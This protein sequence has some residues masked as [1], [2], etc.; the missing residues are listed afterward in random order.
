MIK[1]MRHGYFEL[2]ILASTLAVLLLASVFLDLVTI[3]FQHL[4]L[5]REAAVLLLLACLGGSVVNIPLYRRRMVVSEEPLIGF[6]WIFYRPPMFT[7]Q[8][9]A[10]N[11]GGALIPLGL[12]LYLLGR[13]APGATVVAVILVTLVCKLLARPQPRVGIVLPPLVPPLVAAAVALL[14]AQPNPAPVAYVAGVVGT[15]VGADLANMPAVLATENGVMSIGGAGVFDG[16]FLV[17]LVAIL[18]A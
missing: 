18:L 4:G 13:A 10:V 2:L 8:V 17:G 15:I 5:S 1:A 11:L 16:I 9:I 12:A 14:L 6:P 3:S 7:E